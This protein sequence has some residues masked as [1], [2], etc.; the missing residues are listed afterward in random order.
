MVGLLHHTCHRALT[1]STVRATVH[2]EMSPPRVHHRSRTRSPT[3]AIPTKT[4]TA[5]I[6]ATQSSGTLITRPLYW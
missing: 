2:E 5:N 4:R 1:R 3:A 6:P